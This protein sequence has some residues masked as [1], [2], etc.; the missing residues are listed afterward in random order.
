ISVGERAALNTTIRRHLFAVTAIDLIQLLRSQF[1][2]GGT[3][4]FQPAL[5]LELGGALHYGFSLT[6]VFSLKQY[7]FLPHMFYALS[8]HQAGGSFHPRGGAE[9][10]RRTICGRT[11]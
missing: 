5:Q 9:S 4:E 1:T 7:C 3:N 10:S 8:K 2:D 11:Q 6:S